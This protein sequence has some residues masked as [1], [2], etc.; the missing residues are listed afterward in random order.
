MNL[1]RISAIVITRNESHQIAE[2]IASIRF[3]DEIIV[4][5]SYSTDNTVGI[6]ASHGCRVI[7]PDDWQGFGIQK[8]RALNAATGDWVLSIDADERITPELKQEIITAI[9]AESANGFFLNRKSQFLGKWMRFGGWYPDYTLR[10]GKRE[11][12]S[13][14]PAPVHEKM[15]IEGPVKKLAQPMLHYSYRSID[16]LLRKQKDYA[17]AGAK[18]RIASQSSSSLLGALTR[19]TWT[20]FRAYI[21][22]LGLLDGSR[23]FVAAVAKSQETFW[24]YLATAWQGDVSRQP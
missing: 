11:K 1:P 15:L 3:C 17:L 2:C 5:D 16:D 9:T 21:L 8:Q 14:D 20:F 6:A 4:V 7:Q 10:L 12:V 19:S 18:K 13:F 23:G 22:Q 24:K